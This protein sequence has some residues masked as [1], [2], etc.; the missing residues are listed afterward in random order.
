MK[1]WI[2]GATVSGIAIFFLLKNF[3]L[4]EF[5][6]IKGNI[7]WEY[8]VLL[9]F[10]NLW[11]FIPFS[12]RWYFLLDKKISLGAAYVSSITGVGLNM[13]LPARG[14]DVVRLLINKKDSGLP[15]PNLVSKLF[16][17]KVMDLGT[18]VIIGAAALIFLGLGESK[19]L[20]LILISGSVIVIMILALFALRLFLE[21]IRNLFRKLFSLVNKQ[22]L[23][24]TKL[25]HHLVEF[26]DFLRGD[27]LIKPLLFCFPTW[28]LGY[29]V[30]YWVIGKLIGIDFTTLECLLFIFVGAMGVAIPS[31]PSGIGVF[32]ASMISGFILLGRD[33][34]E[35]FVYATVAHLTQFV[36]LTILA[37]VL[38]FVWTFNS[39]D[40]KNYPKA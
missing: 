12:L 2:L 6:R 37:L 39:K 13:V 32:H 22:D 25:D 18:V 24:E 23:Y 30:N 4:K 40:N 36:L 17:E 5:E 10:T 31:A 1:K 19:N 3:D 26:S 20:S 28:I 8:F 11:S 33:P 7:R 34:G 35:G 38:Y 16:L 14:G 15:L 21:P 27:K 9:I 29:A